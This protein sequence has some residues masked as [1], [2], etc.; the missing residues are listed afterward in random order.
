MRLINKLL[1]GAWLNAT[2]TT[3]AALIEINEL[4]SS[5]PASNKL[6]AIGE[7]FESVGSFLMGA[8]NLE[9]S[10]SMASNMM[11]GMGSSTA[12]VGNYMVF[13]EPNN[14]ELGLLHEM[15]GDGMQALG[16]AMGAYNNM[17]NKQD[18]QMVG[19]TLQS[20]GAG[21]ETLGAYAELQGD[22]KIASFLVAKGAILQ[23][24]GSAIFAAITTREHRDS[25]NEGF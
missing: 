15:L 6:I 1:I 13:L 4:T 10:E 23:A 21:L 11:D 22:E 2:G 24:L 19:N 7:F 25:K 14:P 3:V 9:N 12:M 20:L 16:S 5:H 8:D 18:K 17:Q